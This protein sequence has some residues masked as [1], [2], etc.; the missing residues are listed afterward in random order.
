MSPADERPV[1]VIRVVCERHKRPR[2]VGEFEFV[3][4]RVPLFGEHW[5]EVE[6][7]RSGGR[8]EPR[9]VL[10]V[11]GRR[12]AAAVWSGYLD[13]QERLKKEAAALSAWYDEIDDDIHDQLREIESEIS[14]LEDLLFDGG[15][16]PEEIEFRYSYD[17]EGDQI[18]SSLTDGLLE[19]ARRGVKRLYWFQRPEGD[20]YR[21]PGV[22][23]WILTCG[24]CADSK[25]RYE[26]FTARDIPLQKT[27]DAL[28]QVRKSKVTVSE[29]KAVYDQYAR[30][31]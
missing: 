20:P 19:N 3:Y 5:S 25:E 24:S 23:A 6:Y 27:L 17:F 12:E 1:T 8:W 30:N 2:V 26:R 9:E 11:H 7:V 10:T 28:A 16:G 18:D 4:S 29:L 21:R 15:S 22:V 13:E 31:M 14:S